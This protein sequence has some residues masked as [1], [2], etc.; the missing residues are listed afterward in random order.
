MGWGQQLD[1]ALDP[2]FQH[3]FLLQRE[4]PPGCYTYKFVI[5]SR[6]NRRPA[7][8]L[9]GGCSLAAGH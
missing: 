9:F 5:V 1:M 6:V 8:Q 4:L 2:V 7:D 3:R